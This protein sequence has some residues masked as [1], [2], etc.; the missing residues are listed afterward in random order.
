[1]FSRGSSYRGHVSA[2]HNEN[3]KDFSMQELILHSCA[4]A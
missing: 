3:K 1:L 4:F 2:A